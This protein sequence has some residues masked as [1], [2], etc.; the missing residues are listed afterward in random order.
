LELKFKV[1]FF[2]NSLI[3]GTSW[4]IF[5]SGSTCHLFKLPIWQKVGCVQLNIFMFELLLSLLMSSLE[6]KPF[7]NLLNTNHTV[8]LLGSWNYKTTWMDDQFRRPLHQ[9]QN[10]GKGKED[11]ITHA[12]YS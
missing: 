12:T 6:A 9:L 2:L 1:N 4:G 10:G 5:Q 8:N 7:V 11:I 3:I